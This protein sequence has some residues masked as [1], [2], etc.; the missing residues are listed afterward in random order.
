MQWVHTKPTRGTTKALH[1][2]TWTWCDH[3]EKMGYHPTAMCKSK[4]AIQA[5]TKARKRPHANVAK[6]TR[7]I[8]EDSSSD[9]ERKFSDTDDKD[10]SAEYHK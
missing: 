2:I 4:R 3:C 8:I 1:G 5:G 9:K 10:R 7:K 6:A